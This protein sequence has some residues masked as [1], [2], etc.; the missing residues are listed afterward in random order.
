MAFLSTDRIGHPLSL[1]VLR[2][3]QAQEMWVTVG[4]RS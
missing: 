3:G 1:H 2:G 4:E